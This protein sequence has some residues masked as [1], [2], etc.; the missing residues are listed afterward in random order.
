MGPVTLSFS[1]DTSM[2][3]PAKSIGLLDPEGEAQR[4][5]ETLGATPSTTRRHIPQ[6]LS[7]HT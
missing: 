4:T 3:S 2:F 5:L 1:L 7:I 6:G